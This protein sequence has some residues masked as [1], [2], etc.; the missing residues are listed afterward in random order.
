MH[1]D[2]VTCRTIDTCAR[3]AL[4]MRDHAVGWLPVIDEH[5]Q[6]A[7]VV[8]DRDICMSA[9]TRD[10][11]L[12][13]T[14]VTAAMSTPVYTCGPDDS[15]D[16]AESVMSSHRVRRVPVVNSYRLPVGVLS[17]DDLARAYASRQLA[18]TDVASTL[19]AVVSRDS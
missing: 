1:P 11:P 2:P 13:A 5:G 7:G 16:F 15:V 10:E 6:V 18:S 8:T 4:L 14:P 3:A 12:G 19:A 17:L 9:A